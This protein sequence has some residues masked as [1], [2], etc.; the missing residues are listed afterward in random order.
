MSE[1]VHLD[2]ADDV[3]TI[4]LDSE[5]NRNAL[6]RQLVSELSRRLDDAGDDDS[7]RAVLVRSAGTVFCSGADLT[8][9]AGGG[10]VEG[11]KALIALQRQI[12]T[13]PKPVVV[14]LAGAVRA[15]GLGI[16]GAA[17]LVI[18]AESVTFALTE[19]RLALAP[20]VISVSLLPRFTARAAADL[21]LTGR[22]FDATEAAQHGLVT[23]AV[24]DAELQAEVARS[25]GDLVKGY[26][27]GLRETKTL[28]NH[29]LVARIDALGDDLA[30]LSGELFGSDQAREAMTA[31]LHRTK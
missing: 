25:L 20:A 28:L 29:D 4:T 16:V 15:G 5:H 11:A 9:A 13:L 30:R 23:R 3:A 17:D 26:P 7:A 1:L 6:S 31:F 12:A 10:M 27:Q 18:A 22:T 21:F 2:V 24:P 14:E 19:V 8:E